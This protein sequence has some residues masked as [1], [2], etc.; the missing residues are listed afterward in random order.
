MRRTAARIAILLSLLVIIGFVVVLINQTAQL[1]DLAARMAP[2][3]GEVVFWTL[4]VLYAFCIITPLYLLFSLP[5]PLRPPASETDPAFPEHLERL[6][7][8]LRRNPH[9][10]GRHIATRADVEAALLVLDG[11]A[12]ERTRQ[13]A[14]QVFITTAISQNGSL[15]TF[16]VLAAQSKLVLEIARTYYQ[17]PTLRD[18]LYLYSNVAATAFVAGELEDLDL[19]E[20]VQPVLAAVF[21][22]AAGAVPGLGAATSLFMNSVMTGSANAFLTLRVGIIAK[23]YCRSVV[24]PPR[25]MIRRTAIA[26]ATQMLGGIALSGTRRVAAAVGS[27][28]RTTIGGAFESFGDQIRAAGAGIRGVGTAAVDRLRFRRSPATEPDIPSDAPDE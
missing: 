7:A 24:L 26:E 23:Q 19:T 5:R 9:V 1:V 6:Q 12:N 16:L 18:L 4:L 17:R 8:R 15:D 14:A 22:S 3:L 25:R 27:A 21:G 11:L 10:V 28:T 2:W 13:A 20:Q